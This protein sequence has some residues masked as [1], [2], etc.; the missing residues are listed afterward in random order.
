M[1]SDNLQLD[2]WHGD[3]LS[4]PEPMTS[5]VDATRRA[6]LGGTGAALGALLLGAPLGAEAKSRDSSLQR[7]VIRQVKVLRSKG[8]IRSDEVTSWSVYDFTTRK[9]LV[10]INEDTPRQAASMIKPFVA[11]A[12]FYSLSKRK[13]GLRYT[14]SVRDTMERMIRR[15]NNSATN[16]IMSMVIRANGGGGPRTVE[17]VLKSHGGGIFRQTRIVEKIPANGRTYRNLASAHD[18]SRFLYALWTEQLPYAAELKQIMALPN[19]DRITK[20]VRSIPRN[21][22]VYDKTGSTAMLC[23]NMGIIEARDRNGRSRPYTFIGII[24]R[25]SRAAG[26]RTWITKHSNAMRS[27]SN[28]VYRHQKDRLGLV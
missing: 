8:V 15:S 17:R 2:F 9:K 28:V 23:G 16:E 10:S 13:R 24:Q 20:G 21:V 6:L 3:D 22:R 19:R 18:Y 12:Y 25:G 1:Y 7:D 27:V 14:S 26:Y 11:Q 5:E 4:T